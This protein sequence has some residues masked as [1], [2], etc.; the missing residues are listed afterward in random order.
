MPLEPPYPRFSP[1]MTI[2][3]R[4]TNPSGK[5]LPNKQRFYDR[6]NEDVKKA[7]VAQGIEKTSIVGDNGQEMVVDI[8]GTAVEEPS[9]HRVFKGGSRTVVL[10]GNKVFVK[11]DRLKRP[12][13]QGQGEGGGS[14]AGTGEGEGDVI[15]VPLKREEFLDLYFADMQLPN[16]QKVQGE[17]TETS[18]KTAGHARQGSQHRMD[19]SRSAREA[20][21]RRMALGRPSPAR[22]A[23]EAEKLEDVTARGNPEEIALQAAHVASL[24]QK[25]VSIPWID[26]VDLRF[27]RFEHVPKPTT[28]AVM[29]HMMDVSASMDAP[30]KLVA[31]A[32]AM[33]VGLFLERQYKDVRHVFIRHADKAERCDEKT[34]F[35]DGLS[36]GTLASTAF[37]MTADIARKEFPKDKWNR[38]FAYTGDGENTE[39]RDRIVPLIS[40]LLDPGQGNFRYGVYLETLPG[41]RSPS[42]FGRIFESVGVLYPGKT[43]FQRAGDRSE[44]HPALRKMFG[45]KQ[46]PLLQAAFGPAPVGAS[47]AGPAI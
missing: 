30:R 47:F 10:S 29:F 40:G 19:I 23:T 42:D 25:Q 37:V 22:M 36:G 2:I 38:Y 20:F 13:G 5:S 43:A 45:I 11:G 14:G 3:D 44:V 26:P 35:N 27:K 1:G 34:Y 46:K 21:G 32:F 18:V 9:F 7:I 17:S 16:L 8:P 39:H 12:E 24:K 28:S 31:K 6:L 41:N 4:T 33:T 15:R